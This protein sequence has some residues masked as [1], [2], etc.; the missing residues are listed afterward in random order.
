M[1]SK[2]STHQ[3]GGFKPETVQTQKKEREKKKL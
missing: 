1:I 3:S 2:H